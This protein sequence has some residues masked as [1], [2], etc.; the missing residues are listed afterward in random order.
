MKKIVSLGAVC[1]FVLCL[2]A[3]PATINA[4]SPAIRDISITVDLQ[5][6]GSAVFTEVWDVTTASGTEF[7]IPK[8]NTEGRTITDF[9]VTDETGK[10]FENVP[11]W[12]TEL[13]REEKAGTSGI[14]QA[15]DG[16][17]LCWG[18]GSYGDHVFTLRYTVSGIVQSL[19]DADAM[20]W[21]LVPH[22]MFAPPQ[23]VSVSVLKAGTELTSENTR[24]WA[25]GFSVNFGVQDGKIFMESDR[26]LKKSEYVVLLAGFEQGMFQPIMS[27]NTTME[28]LKQ[29][30]MQGSNYSDNQY[31]DTSSGSSTIF[32]TI[33]IALVLGPALII[34]LVAL[35]LSQKKATEK[36]KP[37]YKDPPYCR[38]IPFQ[39][40]LP[41]TYS[42]LQDLKQLS[43]ESVIIGTYLLRWMRS[44]QVTMVTHEKSG[45]FGSK[46]EEAIQL[47]MPRPEMEPI[48]YKLYMMLQSAAGSD[49]ILQSK[50]FEKWSKK[51]YEKIKGWL[52]EYQNFGKAEIR[53][54][55]A[56]ETKTEKVFF[57]LFS[58]RV[59][60]INAYGEELTQKMFGFKRYLSEFTIIN[61]R[62]AKEVQLW[63]NY[64]VFAQLFGI[65]EQVAQQFATLYPAYFVQNTV[66]QQA[67]GMSVYELIWITR[68]ANNFERAAWNG[69]R[70][71]MNTASTFSGG[72]GHYS[73]GGGFSAGGFSGGGGTR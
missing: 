33:M 61:E 10:V 11:Y 32:A 3:F 25:F 15:S 49:G 24:V 66:N 53:N 29:E 56:A 6:D 72:G 64:L 65:A 8:H 9:T 21:T 52:E 7:Y 50:E 62:T 44:N 14:L 51:N 40:S 5:E 18:F 36:M 48:E 19:Q 20:Y 54:M 69:Y 2:L 70:S 59:T 73:G 43:S 41:A 38:E 1:L 30:A 28:E 27:Q 67:S 17:E 60:V 68:M 42:R 45:F 63:D 13:S 37:E 4:A 58:S 34:G 57:G 31:Q 35:G 39:G 71:G 26:A 46:T 47:Y 55:N 16:Y 23:H 12:D 22:D